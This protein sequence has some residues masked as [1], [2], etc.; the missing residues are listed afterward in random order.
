MQNITCI[1]YAHTLYDWFRGTGGGFGAS[2]MFEGWD[3]KYYHGII[4][5]HTLIIIPISVRYLPF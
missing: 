4:L 2:T 5:T 1:M 3:D